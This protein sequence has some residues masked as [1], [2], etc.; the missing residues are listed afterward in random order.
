[1]KMN[2]HLVVTALVCFNL[3]TWPMVQSSSASEVTEGQT[4]QSWVHPGPGCPDS[5]IDSARKGGELPDPLTVYNQRLEL[6]PGELYLLVGTIKMLPDLQGRTRKLLPY[7]EVDFASQPWLSSAL[8]K[9]APYY[10]ILGNPTYWK[11]FDGRRA[12]L[13]T[14][15]RVSY[16]VDAEDEIYPFHEL[17]VILEASSVPFK[18]N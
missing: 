12:R 11:E 8:R 10:G 16:V 6:A 2:R 5:G 17:E 13:A 9:R 1:M 18:G 7:L 14:R 3:L 4:P 15:A